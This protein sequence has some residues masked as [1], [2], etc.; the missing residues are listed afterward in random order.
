MHAIISSYNSMRRT[1]LKKYIAKYHDDREGKQTVA[2][3][4]LTLRHKSEG[5]KLEA[6]TCLGEL[7][8]MFDMI[9]QLTAKT[10]SNKI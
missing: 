7:E 6:S 1:K 9:S 10:G 4:L 3:L 2:N 8:T 5:M